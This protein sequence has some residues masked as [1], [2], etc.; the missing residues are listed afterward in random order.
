MFTQTVC[1]LFSGKAG[2][3]KTTSADYCL[4]AIA[5]TELTAVKASFARGVKQIAEQGFRWNRNKDDAGRTLLQMVG[6]TGRMYNKDLWASKTIDEYIPD[7]PGYPFDLVFIDDWRY[8]NEVQYIEN[9]GL[10]FPVTVRIDAPER[11]ILKGHAGYSDSS[12]TELDDFT[13][14]YHVDN[15]GTF[16]QLHTQLDSILQSVIKTYTFGEH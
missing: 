16:E 6:R 12:E 9:D 3:G 14:Q 10:Y 15:S 13:F 7:M 4:T 2:T 8:V 1:V 5:R 11:E